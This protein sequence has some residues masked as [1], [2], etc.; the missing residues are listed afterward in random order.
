MTRT[1]MVVGGF[2]ILLSVTMFWVINPLE[3]LR[4]VQDRRVEANAQKFLVAIE[5]YYKVFFEYPWDVLGEP[6]PRET[7][8]K[9]AW[10]QELLTRK[11][12]NPEFGNHPSW[13]QIY[14][15]QSDATVYTCFDPTSMQFQTQADKQG[16][17]R[18]GTSGCLTGCWT[19]WASE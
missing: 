1:Q 7:V 2:I 10:I 9:S 18:N 8:V 6:S 14:L 4:R 13:S 11:M 12:V 16:R 15:T 19:C 5:H 17:N 3:H